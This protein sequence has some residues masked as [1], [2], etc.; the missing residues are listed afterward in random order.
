MR[1]KG[2]GE[3]K[4]LFSLSIVGSKFQIPQGTTLFGPQIVVLSLGAHLCPFHVCFFQVKEKS[5]LTN[6]A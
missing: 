5:R 3:E 4:R 1:F 6:T 2:K